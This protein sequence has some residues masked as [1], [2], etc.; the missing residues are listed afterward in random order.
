M[1]AVLFL[2]TM[3]SWCAIW[4]HCAHRF[5]TYMYCKDVFYFLLF[6]PNKLSEN[7]SPNKTGNMCNLNMSCHS[8]VQHHI[9][10]NK[11]VPGNRRPWHAG[12]GSSRPLMP[13][14]NQY[15]ALKTFRD[16]CIFY[17]SSRQQQAYSAEGFILV[18]TLYYTSVP[19]KAWSGWKANV[20]KP[21][22]A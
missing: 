18:H 14:I 16:E 22:L 5:Y 15:P 9:E 4:H 21:K 2:C 13:S 17:V 12:A 7:A 11:K 20:Q 6:P 8:N 10:A 19:P 1:S 3:I